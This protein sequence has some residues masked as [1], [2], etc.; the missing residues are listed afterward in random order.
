MRA[1]GLALTLAFSAVALAQNAP[2]SGT[3]YPRLAIRNAM[4]ADGN[5]TPASGPYDIIREN[6]RI[7]EVV[8][9][10]P[11]ALNRGAKRLP[12]PVEIEAKGSILFG[13]SPGFDFR[14]LST[15]NMLSQVVFIKSSMARIIE[16]PKK[17]KR[18]DQK[19]L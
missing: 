19:A 2:V 18:R 3:R 16:K 15:A 17:F 11:V 1:P 14:R 12:T 4:I 8:A 6:N 13:C 9:L 5:G 7:V 10:A